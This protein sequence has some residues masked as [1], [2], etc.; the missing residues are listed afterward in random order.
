LSLVSFDSER[1]ICPG[2]FAA[3]R[4]LSPLALT[5]VVVQELVDDLGGCR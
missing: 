2:N 5:Y 1:K 4:E 3:T